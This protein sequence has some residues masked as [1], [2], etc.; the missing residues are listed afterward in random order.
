MGAATGRGGGQAAVGLTHLWGKFPTPSVRLRRPTPTP[1][2]STGSPKILLAA[3]A[4]PA[5]V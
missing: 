1:A 4:S 3:E 2:P 5:A